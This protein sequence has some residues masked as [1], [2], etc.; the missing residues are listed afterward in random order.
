[1]NSKPDK[2]GK[3]PDSLINVVNRIRT[4]LGDNDLDEEEA[5]K[6]ALEEVKAHRAN[7]KTD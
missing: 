5:E 3:Q 1:M 7:K 4:K 2:A 6:L